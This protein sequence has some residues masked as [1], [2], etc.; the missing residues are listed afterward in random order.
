MSL[1]GM[2]WKK[3]HN[4]DGKGQLA[5]SEENK[6]EPVQVGSN[7]TIGAVYHGGHLGFTIQY[8]PFDLMRLGSMSINENEITF[9]YSSS[10]LII[11]LG[12]V[13]MKKLYADIESEES[14]MTY[15]N[16]FDITIV[17][18]DKGKSQSPQFNIPNIKDVEMLKEW[19]HERLSKMELAEKA[20]IKEDLK[21]VK[22][23][24]KEDINPWRAHH[25]KKEEHVNPWRAHAHLA[26]EE[27]KQPVATAA[28]AA[29]VSHDE[30]L[31]LLKLRL[32]KGEITMHEF[33][34][35]KKEL[36]S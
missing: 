35:M 13:D 34:E 23:P 36:D 4:L 24:K 27:Q 15:T 11:P 20:T 5:V 25:G 12:N 28:P 10:R 14:K 16:N 19:V 31:R 26:K 32:A 33:R 22:E 29:N 17:F 9:T 7:I 21:A 30:M 8:P 18:D 2:L 1:R 6:G 3:L